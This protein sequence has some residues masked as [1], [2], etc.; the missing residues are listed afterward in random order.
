MKIEDQKNSLRIT[1]PS[2]FLVFTII[3]IGF[4]RHIPLSHPEIF[5]F[6]PVLSILFICGAFIKGP[7]S[8]LSPLIG[9]FLSDL[10]INPHYGMNLMEPFMLITFCSYFLIF[11]LGKLIGFTDRISKLLYCGVLSALIFHILTC[12]FAWLANPYYQKNLFGLWQSIWIGEPGF[13][14]SYLFLR[15]SLCSTILFNIA[16]GCFAL[17]QI[18]QEQSDKEELDKIQ[19]LA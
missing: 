1:T 18:R 6:S 14:P 8:W 12:G 11:F 13:S 5:N 10:L 2:L 15:N 16:L 3:A 19:S 17:R 7:L 4:C 9:I